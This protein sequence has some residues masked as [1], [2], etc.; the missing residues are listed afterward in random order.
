M[1]FVSLYVEYSMI[2]HFVVLLNTR[3]I[4]STR[5]AFAKSR[6]PLVIIN[7]TIENENCSIYHYA[8]CSS[9]LYQIQMLMYEFAQGCKQK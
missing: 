2:Y 7:N 1:L 8:H 9:V 4:K 5:K 6:L 3:I